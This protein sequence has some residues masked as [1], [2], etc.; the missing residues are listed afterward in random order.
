MPKVTVSAYLFL[1]RPLSS[2]SSYMTSGGS[3]AFCS[4][5]FFIDIMLSKVK[6]SPHLALLFLAFASTF[7]CFALY[8]HSLDMPKP[9]S[10]ILHHSYCDSL[11][12]TCYSVYLFNIDAVNW[13]DWLKVSHLCRILFFI[14]IYTHISL[15]ITASISAQ[16]CEWPNLQLYWSFAISAM[17]LMHHQICYR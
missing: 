14:F 9:P 1:P 12:S 17:Q 7:I 16:Q 3:H 10:H 5:A 11:A 4:H 8:S 2:T 13:T 6:Q 15:H